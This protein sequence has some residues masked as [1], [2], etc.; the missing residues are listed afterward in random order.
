MNMKNGAPIGGATDSLELG[1]HVACVCEPRSDVL[2]AVLPAQRTVE[3][4]PWCYVMANVVVVRA[5]QSAAC[6]R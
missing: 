3:I 4:V 2:C 1:M 5:L 6:V